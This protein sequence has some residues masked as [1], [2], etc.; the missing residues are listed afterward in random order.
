MHLYH[1]Y[2]RSKFNL[3]GEINVE[4]HQDGQAYVVTATHLNRTVSLSADYSIQPQEYK[5]HSRLELS[6]KI[7]IEYDFSL[8]NKTTVSKTLLE[9]VKFCCVMRGCAY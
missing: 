4:T 9:R 6:P 3:T 7:W 8:I 1:L 5:Q 2:N